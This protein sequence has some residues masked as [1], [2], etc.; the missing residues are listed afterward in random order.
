MPSFGPCTLLS[1]ATLIIKWP[2]VWVWFTSSRTIIYGST[3]HTHSCIWCE[4]IM[5]VLRMPSLPPAEICISFTECACT[6]MQLQC[7]HRCA[8]M[9]IACS[10]V[11]MCTSLQ[12]ICTTHPHN[13]EMCILISCH[14]RHNPTTCMRLQ[15][16]WTHYL[17]FTQQ[18]VVHVSTPGQTYWYSQRRQDV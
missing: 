17:V 14:V 16:L 11:F 7:S 18:A 5:L 4:T 6:N 15:K 3:L 13:A 8:W 1:Y 9:P 2:T 10:Q 12:Y